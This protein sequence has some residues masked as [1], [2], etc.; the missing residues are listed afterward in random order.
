MR[1]TTL[2]RPARRRR[3]AFTAA[4]ACVLTP[5]LTLHG[6]VPPK[7]DPRQ[8]KLTSD[9][10]GA[11]RYRTFVSTD[12]PIYRPGEKVYVRAA[13]LHAATH[14]PLTQNANPMVE[15]LGP[16]GDVLTSGLTGTENAVAGLAW[17][18]P[19]GTPGGEYTI[20]VSHPY[21][22][23][24][25]GVRK[26]DVRAFRAPRLKSQI[27]FVRDG[28]GP[29]D[30]VSAS[31]SVTRAEGGVPAGA[32]VTAVAR[33]DGTEVH[34]APTT[35]DAQ[36]NASA[37]FKLPAAIAR[38][39]GTLAF[40]IEDG[41][42]V[43][44]ASKTLPILLQ[45][46]D[47]SIYP[48]G[49]DLVAG[50][51]N[52]VYLEAFTPAKKPADFKGAIVDSHGAEVATVATAH[53][54]RGRFEF[55][56]KAGEKYTLKI[57]QPA[58][59]K[60]TWPLPAAK[61]SGAALAWDYD[62]K[63]SGPSYVA[64]KM[65]RTDP[66]EL[67]VTL[68]KNDKVIDDS[69]PIPFATGNRG[70]AA[71]T[72]KWRELNLQVPD[73]IDGVLVATLWD[74]KTGAPLAERLVFRKPAR[75]IKVD[76]KADRDSYTPGQ[77]V[78]LTVTTTDPDGKPLAATV[79]VSVTDDA[80]L[81]MVEKREQAPRLPAMVLLEADVKDLADAHVYLDPANPKAALATDLL[82]GTQGWRRFAFVKPLDF[83]ARAGDD[84]RR[85]LALRVVTREEV[86]KTAEVLAAPQGGGARFGGAHVDAL[87]AAAGVPADAAAPVPAE[88]AKP[89]AAAA[90]K[91]EDV[92]A[93]R[94]CDQ[95]AQGQAAREADAGPVAAAAAAQPNVAAGGRLMP[96]KPIGEPEMAKK[97]QDAQAGK[98]MGIN[99]RR[100]SLAG[101]QIASFP[102]VREYAHAVRP[103]RQPGDRADFTET[104]YWSAGVKTDATTG[105]ATVSF[106]TSDAV[107][108]FRVAADAFSPTGAL[109]SA[110]ADTQIKSVQPFYVEAKMPIEVTQGDRVLLPVTFVN[111]TADAFGPT[112]PQLP[113]V[114][115]LNFGP[116]NPT[117]LGAN[118]RQRFIQ[119]VN[120]TD[121]AGEFDVTIAGAAGPHADKVTRKLRVKPR[122]FPIEYARGG[123]IG[124]PEA[125]AAKDAVTHTHT[126]EIEIPADVI[127]NSVTSELAVYPTPLANLTQA[128]EALIQS[129]NGCFEQ[130]SSTTYPLVMAQQYFMSHQGVDPKIIERARV[131]LDA[132]YQKL[133]G[134]ECKTTKGYEWFG[135]DPGHDALTAYGLLEFTDMA[136]VRH[137]D[138][139]MLARTRGFIMAMRNGKGGFERKGHTLHT[140][141]ADPECNNSYVT[142]AM[143]ECGTD[144]KEMAVEVKWIKENIANSK[145]SYAVALAA[146]VM[147]LAGDHDAAKAFM[148]KLAKLQDKTGQI[149]GATTSVIGS[150][151]EALAIETTALATL[152]F[153]RQ[154]EFAANVEHSMKWLAEACKAGRFGSTQST[155]LAL[156]AIVT[157][158]KARA[159]PKVPGSVTVTVDG[160]Q[161]GS[162]ASFDENTQGAIKLQD[163]SEMLSPGKHTITIT[164]DRKA[165]TAFSMPFSLA[166]RY[167]T[168]K[169]NS[170]PECK[171]TL[172]TQLRDAK[173]GEGN[174]TEA[175]VTVANK[176]AETIPTP[177][178]LVGIPGGLEVRHDQLKELVKAGQI[179]AY[180]V[181][182]RDVVL[183]WRAM[184]PND[185]RSIPLSLVAAIPGTYTAPASRAYLY[186]TD[187]HKTW[188]DP[189]KV[190]IDPK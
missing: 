71:Q 144:A 64:V 46:L 44:T 188:A 93:D 29:G 69:G 73:N 173:L 111:G 14:V 152:A 162:A 39:E 128:L 11:D 9:L 156:R 108:A 137:V 185:N 97:L 34:R 91:K 58:G 6:E 92:A 2:P 160:K 102:F 139:A 62:A 184:K 189:L 56:P 147:S 32:K 25:P 114:K 148:Q 116:I 78:K 8:A 154:P 66:G 19:A 70:D 36:G 41:G 157:Y 35:I 135:A 74:A 146:N 125:A 138:P 75:Q 76:V 37:S 153:L 110:A 3:F 180:E 177:I 166:V 59:I 26:F 51:P 63:L 113:P 167:N 31:V 120:A 57:A 50:I 109:G 49:G 10:G 53:E 99:L 55:T 124:F 141:I 168:T 158:D 47:L 178:A 104:L 132:G 85:V 179:D 136:A 151:G 112:A 105:Q 79:G 88:D 129:P 18:I 48:E 142:W 181:I 190:E 38:G 126:F 82:L 149:T 33:V 187:E 67:R 101:E 131:Q 80:V 30:T 20:K 87:A 123:L 21:T 81:E 52:R 27:V 163:V 165:E 45:T 182:G 170:A 161:M 84:A 1:P 94:D 5:L 16:K 130:T 28:Y 143:L 24:T 72:G 15:I 83:V 43:E 164:M 155:I 159:R 122:G 115:G 134:F 68:A 4:A 40:L 54:G 150:G 140:W 23:H 119:S 176:T 7:P 186:Y 13:V 118:A 171:L 42:V 121:V 174:L 169:P 86:T 100:K 107:T 133:V 89:G 106:A 175:V 60:T 98:D 103:S 12:K 145:N 61:P 117:A 17:E 127:P 90:G 95:N 96:M 183:Y 172:S 65:T 77:P 22:G